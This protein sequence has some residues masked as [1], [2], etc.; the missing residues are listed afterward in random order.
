MREWEG[1]K[2]RSSDNIP[3]VLR[4]NHPVMTV[5]ICRLC[6]CM[7]QTEVQVPEVQTVLRHLKYSHID[8]REFSLPSVKASACNG[9]NGL[10]VY[11]YILYV[12]RTCSITIAH[13]IHCVKNGTQILG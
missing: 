8:Q 10:V 11:L 5:A 4:K 2:V 7:Y 12:D 13:Y 3:H 1:C 9:A 6:V